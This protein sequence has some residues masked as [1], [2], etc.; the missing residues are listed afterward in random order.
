MSPSET[1]A[2]GPQA[3]K[4][5]DNDAYKFNSSD[6]DELTVFY[7]NEANLNNC[8]RVEVRF[9]DQAVDCYIDS[10]SEVSVISEKLYNKLVLKGLPT[11]EIGINNAVLITAFGNRTKRLKKQVYLEFAIGQDVFENVF[12]VSPQLIGSVI[13][14]CDFARDCGLIIDFNAECIK[15]KRDGILRK[16]GFSQRRRA[17]V[18]DS[19]SLPQ[20]CVL[21]DTLPRLVTP[22]SHIPPVSEPEPLTA[23]R[24][25]F[26][27]SHS[28]NSLEGKVCEGNGKGPSRFE[29]ASQVEVVNEAVMSG[30]ETHASMSN[31]DRSKDDEFIDEDEVRVISR[32]NGRFHNAEDDDFKKLRH[33]DCNRLDGIPI[34]EVHVHKANDDTPDCRTISPTDVATLIY[35]NQNLSLSEK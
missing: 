33:S 31:D 15:Y 25:S 3:Q 24:S 27:G 17:E 18:D 9:G 16:Q 30:C 10:G 23:V 22:E 11:Y 5:S 14:G 34:D 29:V 19:I 20:E 7:I 26:E 21:N 6:K 28:N 13:I 35:K 2:Q 8:P 1:R 12:L 32:I 4:F